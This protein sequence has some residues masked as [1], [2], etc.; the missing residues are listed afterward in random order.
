MSWFTRR[1]FFITLVIALTLITA[2]PHATHAAPAPPL[3]YLQVLA[4]SSANSPSWEY[5]PSSQYTT[6]VDHGG[7]WLLIATEE[8]GYGQSRIAKFNGV[9][10]PEYS[11]QMITDS[12]GTVIGWIRYWRI[13]G[14]ITSG[15]FTYQSTSINSPWNTMSDWINIK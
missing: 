8:Y 2:L 11:N 13:T 7:S 5:P 10:V 15:Q 9:T 4:V 14:T 12:G 1:G 3:S 6:T